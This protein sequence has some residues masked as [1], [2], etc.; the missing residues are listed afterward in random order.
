MSTFI[1]TLL[2]LSHVWSP[3]QADASDIS[4]MMWWKWCSYLWT[5]VLWWNVIITLVFWGFLLPTTDF[6]QRDS[7]HP[8]GAA[9]LSLDH[10]LP[11]TVTLIDWSMNAFVY[12]K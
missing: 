2:V 6:A 3:R 12:D 5:M 1:Y 8:W 7:W 11:I 4:L 10:I 9:K